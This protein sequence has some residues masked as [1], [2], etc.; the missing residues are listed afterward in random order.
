MSN[1]VKSYWNL[2]ISISFL[3]HGIFI[4]SYIPP[5]LVKNKLQPLPAQKKEI[6]IIPQKIEKIVKENK[7]ISDD[8]QALK[9]EARSIPPPY[10]GNVIDRLVVD[11]KN[12]AALDKPQIIERNN[13]EIFISEIS[14]FEAF[15]KTPSY[16]GYY[17][18]IRAKLYNV[19]RHKY[20]IRESGE[21]A[22]SFIIFRNGS[23]ERVEG[24]G[25][26]K[27]LKDLAL[28]IVQESSPFTPF[29]E[30][31]KGSSCQFNIAIDFKNK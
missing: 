30:E 8:I 5:M 2:A 21:V 11:N 10:I 29:P 25:E 4:G 1:G 24:N 31:L 27:I 14:D 17:N 23:L 13:K 16:M 20:K 6:E 3:I 12:I 7:T 19:A 28:R 22:L 26:N 9:E 18:S 15:K